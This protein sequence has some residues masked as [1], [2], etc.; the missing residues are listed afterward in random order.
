MSLNAKIGWFIF[1]A[2]LI[3]VGI[4]LRVKRIDFLNKTYAIHTF[5]D[6]VAGLTEGGSVRLAGMKVGYVKNIF[7]EDNTIKVIMAINNKYK[8][9]SD[10]KATIAME[11]IMAGKCVSINFG[12]SNDYLQNN[13]YIQSAGIVDIESLINNLN[14]TAIKAGQLVEDFNKEQKKLLG[15][16]NEFLI[17]N[18]PKLTNIISNVD[19]ILTVNKNDITDIVVD[20]KN[21]MP[22]INKI[23]DNAN[24]ITEDIAFGR[25]TA[26]KLITSDTLYYELTETVQNAKLTFEKTNNLL[27]NNEDNISEILIHLKHTMPELQESL[28]NIK[29]ISGKISEGEGTIGKLIMDDS[30]YNETNDAI[31][32]INKAIDDQREQTVISTFSDIFF[33]LFTF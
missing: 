10:A 2:L 13:D 23:L 28:A 9:R 1:I 12:Q 8:I 18:A 25:G 19:E 21:T 27:D 33:G 6:E 24:S 22:K 16:T 11:T 5:F 3:L 29:K 7:P 26:G 4:T 30:I 14:L 32:G 31:K 20:I 15:N 17:H